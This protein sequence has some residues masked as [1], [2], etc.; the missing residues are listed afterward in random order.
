MTDS[1]YPKPPRYFFDTESGSCFITFTGIAPTGWVGNWVEVSRSA[2]DVI[3][4]DMIRPLVTIAVR[5]RDVLFRIH[6][7]ECY[8]YCV[9]GPDEAYTF[10]RMMQ[11]LLSETFYYKVELED[12]RWLKATI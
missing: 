8:A 1:E 10:A 6:G 4:K 12:L 3:T 2:Y 11:K 7:E 9:G 5:Q